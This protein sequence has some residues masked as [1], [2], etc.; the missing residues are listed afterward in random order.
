MRHVVLA[1]LA[2]TA[3]PV[4]AQVAI[5]PLTIDSPI[6]AIAADPRAKA[7]LDAALP[8]L[9]AHPMYDSFKAMSL[10]AIQPMSNGKVSDAAL[11]QVAQGLA[12]IK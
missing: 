9:T 3:A 8:G 5:A 10:K 12:A 1:A 2:L 11:A 7:V 6:E 4:A